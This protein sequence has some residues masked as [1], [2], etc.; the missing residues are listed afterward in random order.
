MSETDLFDLV[1]R[2]DG[3]LSTLGVVAL[4]R[5]A[6]RVSVRSRGPAVHALTVA[7]ALAVYRFVDKTWQKEAHTIAIHFAR[8]IVEQQLRLDKVDRVVSA[9]D[10]WRTEKATRAA[11]SLALD[12][13]MAMTGLEAVKR[14]FLDLRT[15][16]LLDQRRGTVTKDKRY[17]VCMRGNPGTGKTT[18]AR[19][20][21]EFLVEL[22]V[23]GVRATTVVETSGAK[24]VHGGVDELNKLFAQ[25]DNSGGGVLFI[26]EAYQLDPKVELQGKRVLDALLA[27]IENR[28]G[29]VACVLAGY[30]KKL[31]AL[32][33]HNEGLPS[34]FPHVLDFADYSDDELRTMFEAK[35]RS[36]FAGKALRLCE[37]DNGLS[38]R[39]LARRIGA[40]RGRDGFG[41]ARAVA[42]VVDRVC[43]LQSKRIVAEEK[44][45][46][47]RPNDLEFL[48]EDLL[49]PEPTA[50]L[51]R[52]EAWGKLQAMI[53]L[54]K[55]KATV[56]A[57][58][59][60]VRGN[61]ERELREEP[62]LSV[63]LNRVFLG[64]PGT[65]K[66]TVAKLYGEILRDLGMLSKGDM[67]LKNP[68]DMIGSVLGESEKNT[69]SI[70]KAAEGCVLVI[71]EAY[72]LHG[73]G[74][75]LAGG[76]IGGGTDM[77]K[78]AVIDTLVAEVQNVPGEDRCVLMLGYREQ[79]VELLT[80]A[81]PGLARRFAIDDAFVFDD[82][83]DSEL[84][85]ILNGKLKESGLTAAMDVKLAAIGVLA[86]QR[87]RPNFGNGGAVANLVSRAIQAMSARATGGV[88][89]EL[90]RDDFGAAAAHAVSEFD[91]RAEFRD[92]LGC[93]NIVD[94][95]ESYKATIELER[96]RGRD[97]LAKLALNFRFVGPPGTGK[98]VT[99]TRVGK[100]FRSL[101]VLDT[102]RVVNVSAADLIAGYVGQTAHKTREKLDEALGG[103]LFIDEAYR[104]SGGP[105][106][107]ASE[108][109]DEL[110]DALTKD[111]Y[112]GKLVVVLAGYE[113]DIET[114]MQSNAGL[115]S[116]FPETVRFDAF[117]PGE[118]WHLLRSKLTNDEHVVPPDAEQSAI[119]L[120]EQLV[121]T[122]NWGSGRDVGTA[123]D[124][125]CRVFAA[126]RAATLGC[127]D[128]L[129]VLQS[130]LNEKQRATNMAS[131]SRQ[132]Q[133]YVEQQATSSGASSATQLSRITSVCET[134]ER[135]GEA[136]HD[137]DAGTSSDG[138]G[139]DK[140]VSDAIW[141]QLQE[142][143]KRATKKE[144]ERRVAEEA[145]RLAA[146]R[147]E[148]E[149]LEM[150]RFAREAKLEVERKRM[151]E[152]A[153]QAAER[154][155]VAEQNRRR[156]ELERQREA[157]VEQKLREMGVC[158]AGYK[159]I[160]S[161]SGY[162]CAGGSH[163]VSD[164]QLR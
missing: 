115:A 19:I 52:S 57:L 9:V 124:K 48:R 104:L 39:I 37:A 70:L 134:A 8:Y 64:N 146:E 32:F 152:L 156:H 158:V 120:F 113:P 54:A 87:R 161:G 67:I 110:V 45:S 66:T 25:L 150:E 94:L 78:T 12:K 144:E 80:K 55:V 154:R 56:V 62:R 30:R 77:Y 108:A 68:S 3:H 88:V 17:G 84:M 24:L 85:R 117:T 98:T 101:G 128:I 43:E 112:K 157:K 151:E 51:E 147:A 103:V 136:V 126:R 49:G 95:M 140:G 10:D 69:K 81:N 91:V 47:A 72:G 59:N 143:R 21:G 33:E 38:L 53:G 114:L 160:R 155:R 129:G 90:T 100:L 93:R 18:V 73:G 133:S 135:V 92:M 118:C 11:H 40:S 123:F 2:S 61:Y 97:P 16:V 137:G 122:P 102:D 125:I 164:S 131:N 132:K 139:R 145:A 36:K 15:S 149:R 58:V 50:A 105:A 23:L 14:K 1:E 27:E 46:H 127:D 107:F 111:R 65:G 159:W 109:V 74:S 20:Y 141:Q 28:V 75:K 148:Q 82:Y 86:Q 29:T 76:G 121:R 22:G 60:L 13:L 116:R 130:M 138:V 4:M 7:M 162:R 42:N 142:D 163:F 96:A 71:D 26:D 89:H 106:S 5:L 41:N 6:A 153:R 34:R 44:Q 35:L 63:A 99:A 31:E 79:M 119:A 83:T